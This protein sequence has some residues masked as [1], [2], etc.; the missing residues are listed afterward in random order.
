VILHRL[1]ATAHPDLLVAPRWNCLAATLSVELREQMAV[2]GIWQGQMA[3][4]VV[5][6]S[7][8]VPPIKTATTPN[9]LENDIS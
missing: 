7:I 3:D 9:T 1:W 4:A 6:R 8:H 5:F 2:Q